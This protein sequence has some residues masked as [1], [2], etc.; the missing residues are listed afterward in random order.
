MKTWTGS[1]QPE[2]VISVSRVEKMLTLDR[3]VAIAS[4]HCGIASSG[5]VKRTV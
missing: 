4:S 5:E 1:D 2:V 3:E